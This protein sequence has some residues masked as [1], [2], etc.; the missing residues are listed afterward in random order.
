VSI[1]AAHA[2]RDG[3]VVTP[4][5]TEGKS[6]QSANRRRLARP[7]ADLNIVNCQRA[8]RITIYGVREPTQFFAGA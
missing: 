8:S 2:G 6:Q 3:I 5:A 4:Y 7:A 1:H